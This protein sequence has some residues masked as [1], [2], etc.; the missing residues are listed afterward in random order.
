MGFFICAKKILLFVFRAFSGSLSHPKAI[1]KK[2][3]YDYDQYTCKEFVQ[4]YR[5]ENSIE[6]PMCLFELISL[7]QLTPIGLP[8]DAPFK[9]IEHI[10]HIVEHERIILHE[11][12]TGKFFIITD[13]KNGLEK[14]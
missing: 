12:E 5:S 11:P 10:I 2:L 14:Y 7:R 3:L 13:L 9:I 1:R 4:K 6:K 8:P